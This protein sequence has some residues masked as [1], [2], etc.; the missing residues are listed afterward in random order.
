MVPPC[1]ARPLELGETVGC[2]R[3]WLIAAGGRRG[4]GVP[5][6]ARLRA[7]R[8]VW[9]AGRGR[10]RGRPVAG[11]G[12]R[13]AGGSAARSGARAHDHSADG[14]R[15]DRVD[16]PWAA[17]AAQCRIHR[18]RPSRASRQLNG[19]SWGPAPWEPGHRLDPDRRPVPVG[20]AGG[21]QRVRPAGQPPRPRWAAVLPRVAYHCADGVRCPLA[22]RDRVLV[23]T[24]WAATG[25]LAGANQATLRQVL[26]SLRPIGNA[27]AGGAASRPDCRLDWYDQRRERLA[28]SQPAA[29]RRSGPPPRPRAG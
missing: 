20:A 4:V 6:R 16:S 21:Q 17:V 5:A 28:P 1:D 25:E 18:A 11:A 9:L 29:R 27:L 12:G 2:H 15:H 13:V 3:A 7:G 26:D 24:G 14:H 8:P 23:V 10:Q 19:G 22:L